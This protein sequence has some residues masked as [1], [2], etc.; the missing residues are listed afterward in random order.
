MKGKFG[1]KTLITVSLLCMLS[2]PQVMSFAFAGPGN[3]DRAYDFDFAGGKCNFTTYEKKYNKSKIYWN[4]SKIQVFDRVYFYVLGA[5]NESGTGSTDTT[6]G[7]PPYIYGGDT[8]KFSI[9]NNVIETG[10]SH[11]C[12]EACTKAPYGI[13][14]GQWSPDSYGNYTVMNN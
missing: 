11:A 5:V 1:V 7:D 8:G 3:V 10:F 2:V 4:V 13:M 14:K 9:T 12:V 6:I